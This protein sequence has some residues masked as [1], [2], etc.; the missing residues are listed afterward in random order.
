VAGTEEYLDSEKYQVRHWDLDRPESLREA[1]ARLNEIRRESTALRSGELE[2]LPV[3]NE[4]LVA[5]ARTDAQAGEV[6]VIVVNLDPHH[7]QAGWIELPLERLGVDAHLPYQMD[8]LVGGARYLWQGSRNYVALDPQ[9]FPAHIFRMR[10]RVRTEHDFD[11][12]L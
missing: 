12:Y 2:F 5:Y 7:A 3:D 8:D 4:L 11:Y 6:L 10:R 9:A 1:M